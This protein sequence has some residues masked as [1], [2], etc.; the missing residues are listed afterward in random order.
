MFHCVDQRGKCERITILSS[1]LVRQTLPKVH[2]GAIVT[3][4]GAI[5]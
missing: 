2:K 5:K 1:F 3:G 4:R